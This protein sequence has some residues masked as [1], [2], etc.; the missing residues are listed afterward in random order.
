[1][2]KKWNHYHNFARP[3]VLAMLLISLTGCGNSPNTLSSTD[4]ANSSPTTQ[5]AQATEENTATVETVV[6]PTTIIP[7]STAVPEE[8][9]YHLGFGNDTDRVKYLPVEM[10]R[11]VGE[12]ISTTISNQE[13]IFNL[14]SYERSN[15]NNPKL[16]QTIFLL[17]N[18]GNEPI[19]FNTKEVLMGVNETTM[20]LARGGAAFLQTEEVVSLDAGQEITLTLDWD[21]NRDFGHVWI[22]VNK[23]ITSQKTVR[24]FPQEVAFFLLN[25]PE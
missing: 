13:V 20:T 24:L 17:K 21:S 25:F 9:L 1:M 12:P 19:S 14:V 16:F 22:S 23:P 10:T 5:I 11:G 8:Q 15:N 18:N 2:I 4:E 6:T 7:T 3:V